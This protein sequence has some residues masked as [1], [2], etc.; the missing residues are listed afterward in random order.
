MHEGP[1]AI[2]TLLRAVIMLT[3]AIVILAALTTVAIVRLSNLSTRDQQFRLVQTDSCHVFEFVDQRFSQPTKTETAR[4]KEI[5]AE[6]SD[7][8]RKAVTDCMKA[9]DR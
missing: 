3:A 6:F 7:Q 5:T 8:L 9:G 1:T 4:Q 2:R